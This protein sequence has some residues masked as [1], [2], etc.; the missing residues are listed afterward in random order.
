VT[1]TRMII[2]SGASGNY[3]ADSRPSLLVLLFSNDESYTILPQ[4]TPKSQTLNIHN[5]VEIKSIK[6]E[7]EGTYPGNHSADV[8][9]S[10][11]ELFGIG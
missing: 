10:D 8:A 2:Y 4:D 11:I 9:I 3:L 6:I 7:V 5:A 1:L